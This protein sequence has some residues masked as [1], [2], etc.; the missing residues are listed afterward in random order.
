MG[1]LIFVAGMMGSG[2]SHLL[3]E[4]REQGVTKAICADHIQGEAVR[5][6]FPYV[7]EK[8][9]WW[10]ETWPKKPESLDLVKL[11]RDTLLSTDKALQGYDGDLVIA[12]AI[13]AVDWFRRA[14]KEA[15]NQTCIRYPDDH[16]LKLHMD[17]P[18]SIILDQIHKRANEVDYRHHE[19]Q[20]FPDVHA[21]QSHQASYF[22]NF[23]YLW[24]RTSSFD[25]TKSRI[26]SFAQ[27]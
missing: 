20:M 3:D 2:K 6:A 15:V 12:G 9:I 5:R 26:Q 8:C 1:K 4:L 18:A 16:V 25:E 14:L 23:S 13:I 22:K 24:E 11:F 7:H 10:W 17:F 19:L 27:N 21:V